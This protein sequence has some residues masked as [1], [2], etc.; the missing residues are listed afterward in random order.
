MT[1]FSV[2]VWQ[3]VIKFLQDLRFFLG[4]L[5]DKLLRLIR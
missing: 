4:R 5:T 2:N 3:Q 1:L